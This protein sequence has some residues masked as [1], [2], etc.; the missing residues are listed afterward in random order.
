MQVCP[1]PRSTGA[2]VP[3]FRDYNFF[4]FLLSLCFLIFLSW[5]CITYIICR[6]KKGEGSI[7]WT[8][9]GYQGIGALRRGPRV[10]RYSPL[11]MVLLAQMTCPSGST[12]WLSGKCKAIE[13]EAF[14]PTSVGPSLLIFRATWPPGRAAELV[15]LLGFPSPHAFSLPIFPSYIQPSSCSSPYPIPTIPSRNCQV[16]TSPTVRPLN[17]CPLWIQLPVPGFS[18]ELPWDTEP[19]PVSGS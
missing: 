8:H 1:T 9:W 11:M 3:H 17:F 10:E 18:P 15:G 14:A 2:S 6:K 7:L 12:F 5:I 16:P 19:V 4:F 13:K